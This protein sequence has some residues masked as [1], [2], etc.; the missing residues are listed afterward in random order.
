[1][2]CGWGVKAGMVSV[3]GW[4]VKLCDPLVT[5]ESYLSALRWCIMIKALYK[6]QILYLLYFADCTYLFS[7]DGQMAT[8]LSELIWI[9]DYIRVLR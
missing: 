5:H 2:P 4:Q 1:M 3:C 7:T 9:A 6:Y 8:G